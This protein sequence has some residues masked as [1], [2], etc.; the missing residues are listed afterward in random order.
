MYNPDGTE[1]E[2]CDASGLPN[3]DQPLAQS[4]INPGSPR[5]TPQAGPTEY[6]DKQIMARNGCTVDYDSQGNTYE[7]CDGTI[8]NLIET[9]ALTMAAREEICVVET[10]SDGPVTACFTS[11]SAVTGSDSMVRRMCQRDVTVDRAPNSVPSHVRRPCITE[12][13]PDDPYEI[14]L[15]CSAEEIA[16]RGL[17]LKLCGRQEPTA[18]T[19]TLVKPFASATAS[20]PTVLSRATIIS[21][22]IFPD[23]R[24]ACSTIWLWQETDVSRRQSTIVEPRMSEQGHTWSATEIYPVYSTQTLICADLFRPREFT[25]AP[26]PTSL[27]TIAKRSAA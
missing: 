7:V 27:Y 24:A 4:T 20:V 13:D 9:S 3:L 6:A 22:L 25:T 16:K 19:L 15:P 17:D 18:G 5:Y 2:V 21:A 26:T 1:N 23:K 8:V 12:K 11:C 14:C 10:S